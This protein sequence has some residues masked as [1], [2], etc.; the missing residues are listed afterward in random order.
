MANVKLK[1]IIMISEDSSIS[2]TQII[3]VIENSLARRAQAIECLPGRYSLWQSAT[4]FDGRSGI[5]ANT[6]NR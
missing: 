1:T 6:I 4:E 3:R 5:V 2:G